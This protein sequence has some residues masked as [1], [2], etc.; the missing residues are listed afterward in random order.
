[1]TINSRTAI[2]G[3]RSFNSGVMLVIRPSLP[4]SL[5]PSVRPSIP[6]SPLT[7]LRY[8]ST[9]SDPHSP[10]QYLTTSLPHFLTTSFPYYHPSYTPLPPFATQECAADVAT[11]SCT[12]H[13]AV[14]DYCVF[15]KRQNNRSHYRVYTSRDR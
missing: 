10:P 8:S 11:H 5:C 2:S 7:S 6:L 1:M 13:R 4:S 12:H 9:S 14:R 15:T 3:I